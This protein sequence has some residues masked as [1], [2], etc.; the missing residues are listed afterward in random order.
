[1][2]CSVIMYK[3]FFFSIFDLKKKNKT[4]SAFNNFL[5]LYYF[6]LIIRNYCYYN[7]TNLVSVYSCIQN[8]ILLNKLIQ[9]V[10]FKKK[11]IYIQW[12]S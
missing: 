5:I 8:S 2:D 3:S 4:K 12:D 11:N 6:H 10:A 9:V 7:S 1:M